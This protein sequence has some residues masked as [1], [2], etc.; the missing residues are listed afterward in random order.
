[1]TFQCSKT[2]TLPIYRWSS[3]PYL[4][5]D[6]FLV[7]HRINHAVLCSGMLPV[8]Y[9]R[10]ANDSGTG[11]ISKTQRNKFSQEYSGSLLSVYERSLQESLHQEIG[12]YEGLGGIDIM[13]E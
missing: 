3:S 9:T 8:H 11:V 5:N 6:T 12:S 2:R 4:L 10:F 7:N 13:T 1:M